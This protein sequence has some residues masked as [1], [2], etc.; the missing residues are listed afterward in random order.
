M[1]LGERNIPGLLKY[2]QCI[3]YQSP[4]YMLMWM[5]L[6]KCR[7]GAYFICNFSIVIQMRW[8]F[9]SALSSLK[10]SDR[11]EICTCHDS[12]VVVACAKFCRNLIPYSG[13]RLKP[14]SHCTWITMEKSFMKWAPP[15][16]TQP[17]ELNT[18]CL[19]CDGYQLTHWGRDKMANIFP[20]DIFNFFFN[21]NVWISIKISLSS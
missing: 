10:R 11:Y 9:H 14:I 2:N 21:E 1:G 17:L 3:F 20:D 16:P 18:C 7:P 13:V 5:L 4:I 12:C 15:P 6:L 8:K 19:S